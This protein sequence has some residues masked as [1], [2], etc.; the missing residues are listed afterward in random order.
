MTGRYLDL[1]QIMKNGRFYLDY[2]Y[3]NVLYV[4]NSAYGTEKFINQ[5]TE[6]VN[7]LGIKNF[8]E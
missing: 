3:H 2:Y 5:L 8:M 7:R 6:V 4:D 1:S